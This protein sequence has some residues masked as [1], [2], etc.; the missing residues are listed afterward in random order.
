[1]WIAIALLLSAATLLS[2][3][4]L[5]LGPSILDRSISLDVLLACAIAGIGAYGA[6][7]REASVL[8]ILLV[9]ALLG[10]VGSVS[11][12]RFVA[13]QEKSAPPEPL[14]DVEDR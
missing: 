5:L 8:P 10:F 14:E 3:V 9:L 6:Y 12:S 7:H 1:M 11:V 4:R 13:K 2:M